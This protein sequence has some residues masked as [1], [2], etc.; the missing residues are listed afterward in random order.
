[1]TTWIIDLRDKVGQRVVPDADIPP[2]S[3]RFRKVVANTFALGLLKAQAEVE[4]L[5]PMPDVSSG[6][7][8][9]GG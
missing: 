8:G 5:P 4:S 1:M 9:K 6:H 7:Q 2:E 3:Q